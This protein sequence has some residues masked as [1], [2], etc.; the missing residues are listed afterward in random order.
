MNKVVAFKM[1]G[2]AALKK[3]QQLA[4]DS[5]N[6]VFLKHATKRM[7]ERKITPKQVLDALRRG[8]IVEGPALDLKGGW[9]MTLA[10]CCAGDELEVT[11][12]ISGG[13]IVIITMYES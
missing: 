7:R 9:K 13:H 4:A 11:A 3:L 5:K 2:P 1:S 10:V 12:V 8:R 6:I